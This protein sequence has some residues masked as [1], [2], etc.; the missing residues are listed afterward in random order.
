[1]WSAILCLI[2]YLVKYSLVSTP[3]PTLID[4]GLMAYGVGSLAVY[5]LIFGFDW[6]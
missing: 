5:L 3:A 4:M 6:S 2:F 1:M